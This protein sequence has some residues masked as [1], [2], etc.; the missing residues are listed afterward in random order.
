MALT[1]DPYQGFHIGVPDGWELIRVNGTLVV[2]KDRT[3]TELTAVRPALMTTDL[4]A[5]D[6]FQAA[7]ATLGQQFAPVGMTLTPTMTSSGTQLPAA[8]LI[9][10]SQQAS[11]TGQARIAVLPFQTAHSSSILAFIASWAPKG[12]FAADGPLLSGI[13]ACYGPQQATLFRVVK[14]AAFTYALPLGWQVRNEDQNSIE[15]FKG[16]DAAANYTNLHFLPLDSGVNSPKTLFAWVTHKLGIQVAQTLVFISLPDETTVTGSVLSKGIVEFT[17]T[18]NGLAI[19][20]FAF[21]STT[22]PPA[23]S[24]SITAGV[25]RIAT[26]TTAAWNSLG[27]ALVHIIGSTQHDFTQNLQ[28]WERLSQQSQAF[29]QQV[30]GFDNA[31]NGVDLVNDPTTGA[32][33]EAPY[34]NYN[35]SGPEGPG[36]YSPAGTKLTVL[37]P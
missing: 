32:T 13:G 15:I 4:T 31:I 8:S 21:L 7:L 16:S 10:Q 24:N 2:T 34:A 37:G 19:H 35:P 33:F 5:A 9:I 30:Q 23:G 14:D 1:S 28:E 3:Y 36:Y 29:G 25:L 22:R 18:V 6:Y 27:G 12:Q 17:G 26:A 20:G 11:L